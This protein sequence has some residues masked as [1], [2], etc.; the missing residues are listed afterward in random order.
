MTTPT[1]APSK[2]PARWRVELSRRALLQVTAATVLLAPA[3]VA[4]SA[5]TRAPAPMPMVKAEAWDDG[6]FWDDGTG[7][8]E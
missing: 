5:R 6:T 1:V 7:W 4:T 2:S 3:S 8:V